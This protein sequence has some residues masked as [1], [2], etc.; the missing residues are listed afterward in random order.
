VG[1]DYPKVELHV[2]LEST[3]RPELLLQLAQRN[4]CPLPASTLAGLARFCAATSFGDLGRI[5]LEV[6]K[7]L[8]E[9]QDFRDVLLSYAREASRQGAVYVEAIFNPIIHK[10]RGVDMDAVFSGYCDGAQEA[11]E[12]YGLEVRLTPDADL[13]FSAAE[14]EELA[15]YAVAYRKR[16]VVGFGVSG[17]D[18]RDSPAPFVRA[19]QIARDGGLAFTPHAGEFGGADLVRFA[20]EQLHASR[21]RHG[22]GAIEDPGLLK[23]IAEAGI[24]FDICPISNVKLG[25]IPTLA[26]HPLPAFV[27]AGIRCSISS[28]DPVLLDTDLTRNCDAASS[29]GVSPRTV[30]EAG[31]AGALC[32]DATRARVSETGAAFEWSR[33]AP[34]AW[35]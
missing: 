25:A 14:A 19:S 31:V 27:R 28:D 16:G 23:E 5:W 7:V 30:F 22:L 4:D 11:R 1:T 15:R 18:Y 10:R 29:L 32:D 21:I 33:I 26:E 8:R 35:T 12:E 24:G 9:E 3:M 20:V 34:S 6:T 2:H 17:A 13:W